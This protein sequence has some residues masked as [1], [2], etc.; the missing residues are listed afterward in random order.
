[1]EN[2]T[3]EEI[4]ILQTAVDNLAGDQASDKDIETLFNL[5]KKLEGMARSLLTKRAPDAGNSVP[6]TDVSVELFGTAFNPRR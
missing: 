3:V 6:N 5:Y 1:M 4:R 2:L